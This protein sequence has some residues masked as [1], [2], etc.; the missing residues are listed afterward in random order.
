M[1]EA[2]DDKISDILNLYND[3]SEQ[4]SNII[5]QNDVPGQV[6]NTQHIGEHIQRKDFEEVRKNLKDLIDKNMNAID[7]LMEI[8]LESQQPRAYEVASKLMDS[9]AQANEKLLD[10]HKKQKEIDAIVLAGKPNQVTNNAFFIGSTKELMN[11]IRKLK[12]ST[13]EG[14]TGQNAG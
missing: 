14:L 9:C 3:V 5:P 11:S 6:I 12:Q 2:P 7:S 4:T 10:L 1:N 8:A 13:T